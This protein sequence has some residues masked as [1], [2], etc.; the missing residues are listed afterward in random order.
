MRIAALQR[1]A[2][3]CATALILPAC[4]ARDGGTTPP[5]PQA[6]AAQSPAA[7]GYVRLARALPPGVKPEF[8]RGPLDTTRRI[9]NL[10]LVFKL[11]PEQVAD[12][13]ALKAAQLDPASPSYHAW[14][15]PEGYA[16][17][18]GAKPADISRAKDWL[19][20]Q[21]LEV[22]DVSRL[23]SRVTFAGTVEHLQSAFHAQMR[24]Y[25]VVGE[26]HYAMSAPPQVPVELGHAVLDVLNT[27]DFY[28]KP[29]S[30][31]MPAP[32]YR[33]GSTNGFTPPDWAN[34]YDVA[35]AYSPGIGG[36]LITGAGVTIAV[37]G[38][39]KI[40][41]SDVDAWRTRF[42][43]P[44]STVTM[45]LVPGTGAAVGDNGSG[46]EA[47]LD[48]E[49]S[50]GIG[51]GATVNYVYTGA[52][53]PNVDDAALY[54]IENDV[55]PVLS[56]SWGSCD[57]VYGAPQP[58]GEGLEP[59]DQTVIEAYA[60][61]ANVLGIT[62][63]A[64]SGDWGATSCLDSN[65]GGVGGL[66]VN[67]PAAYAGVTAVGGTQFATSA[68]TTGTN[69]YFSAYSTAERVWNEQH[70][71]TGANPQ[72]SAGGGGISVF[73][74]RPSYQ[75]SIPTCTPV[76]SLP[77]SGITAANMRQLPDISFTA[78]G[79]TTSQFPL[80][81]I[82]TL[83]GAG[84]DCTGTAG[85]ES[86]VAGGGTSFSAPAFAGVVSLMDQVAGGR[87]GNVN[88]LLYALATAAPTVFH[89]VTAGNNE[90]TCNGNDPGCGSGGV[91]GYAAGTG[92]DCATGLGSVDVY[93]LL[94]S[95][96]SLT[97]T[98]TTLAATPTS[99]AE[100]TPVSLTATVAIPSGTSSTHSLAGGVVT[101][102]FQSYDASGNADLTAGSW[103]L[104]TGALTGSTTSG[105][106]ALSIAIPP[107]LV[108]PGA[109]SADVYAM[110]GGDA[111]HFP[112]VSPKVTIQFGALSMAIAPL[113]PMVRIGGTLHFT[114][115]GGV[116]ATR[117]FTGSDSTC[118][119][120]T[121]LVCSGIDEN[122]GD[123]TA[124]NAAGITQVFGMDDDGAYASTLVYV[125]ISPPDGGTAVDAGG[126]PVDSGT[127]TRPGGPRDAASDGASTGPDGSTAGGDGGTSSG[128][129]SSGAGDAS[130]GG[131]DDAATGAGDDADTTGLDSGSGAGSDGSAASSGK[132]G[133]GCKTAGA[134]ARDRSSMGLA[135][136]L[137]L[138]FGLR[139]RRQ[140]A[141]PSSPVA[142][143]SPPPEL[144][145]SASHASAHA[146]TNGPVG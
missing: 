83:D 77:V 37:V 4:S 129:A 87:L 58:T 28:P 127:G 108:R 70:A 40:A 131:A 51:Q 86:I 48:V 78:A 69:G 11:S 34:V 89:D 15:T 111:N 54:A 107:G 61:A 45:T 101:F 59:G 35:R 106:A 39:A 139:R 114:S 109:Q 64:A 90:V 126:P 43:L 9:E 21:G 68:L 96:S 116:G 46:F 94:S 145:H 80:F 130:T 88:P 76:G 23:G 62:Y 79:V 27:H 12:R 57:G 33:S 18:F 60:S 128:G 122:L 133:C 118:N 31:R 119:G 75:A 112:S 7:A 113:T 85:A 52:D 17:R 36:Q 26:R 134:P 92:Y 121:S 10:S 81:A 98:T 38:I 102:A 22:H 56:E 63:V 103:T 105:T 53:D 47:T 13:E 2:L 146:A 50:G 132:S 137:L 138:G 135:G 44:A 84:T 120:T 42:G 6:Q 25:D 143:S 141:A 123:F 55:A 20:S 95:M 82:C 110:Y 3:A 142:A 72:V 8:D 19:A 99:A 136:L 29:M 32:D 73:F 100:G 24:Q 1:S 140:S 144:A 115:T 67:A 16:A 5:G 93:N 41:Q 14:L 66:Y 97:P 104:G 124:G 74:S 117:W 125:G 91:Y 30:R 65:L 49:W 71:G